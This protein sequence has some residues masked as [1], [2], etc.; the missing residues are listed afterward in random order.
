MARTNISQFE[1]YAGIT[2][3]LV[4]V[5]G[6][7]FMILTSLPT[8]TKVNAQAKPLKEIP[9]DLF[10]SENDINKMIRVL[11]TPAGVP[12]TVNPATL[13]RTNIFENP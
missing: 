1:T 3:M 9:R 7:V 4:A 10:S 5:L 12:V 11:N 13:G 2:L 8:A 6:F